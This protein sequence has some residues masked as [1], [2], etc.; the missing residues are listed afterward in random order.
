[1]K[2]TKLT[3]ALLAAALTVSLAGCGSAA[4]SSAA[5]EAT[6]EVTTTPEPTAEPTPEPTPEPTAAP[7]EERGEPAW[8]T[9]HSGTDFNMDDLLYVNSA[10]YQTTPGDGTAFCASM[11]RYNYIPQP[12]SGAPS[13]EVEEDPFYDASIYTWYDADGT[14]HWYRDGKGTVGSTVIEIDPNGDCGILY[15]ARLDGSTARGYYPT[16]EA[17]QRVLE[18]NG[19]NTFLSSYTSASASSYSPDTSTNFYQDYAQYLDGATYKGYVSGDNGQMDL[20]IDDNM[21]VVSMLYQ[22]FGGAQNARGYFPVLDFYTQE[23]TASI[24]DTSAV[25]DKFASYDT[26]TCTV[27]TDDGTYEMPMSAGCTS[28]LTLYNN[29]LTIEVSPAV[30]AFDDNGNSLGQ[31]TTLTS[32][33]DFVLTE[34]VTF[35]IR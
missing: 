14:L 17:I 33:Q 4:S 22:L 13:G 24:P 26:V 21:N 29:D 7:A 11:T 28:Y 15:A 20:Y 27:V 23:V 19:Q 35:T 16:K 9:S 3:A 6:P 30:E 5:P 32:N 8:I 34:P 1:M 18:S 2:N 25:T 12:G 31:Q 10:A